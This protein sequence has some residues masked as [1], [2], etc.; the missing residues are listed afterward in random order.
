MP[1]GVRGCR[2]GI[3]D[4]RPVRFRWRAAPPAMRREQWIPCSIS[5]SAARPPEPKRALT[6]R[7]DQMSDSSAQAND[8][9]LLRV[10]GL[11]PLVVLPAGPAMPMLAQNGTGSGSENSQDRRHGSGSDCGPGYLLAD[12]DCCAQ[13]RSTVGPGIRGPGIRGAGIRGAG[14]C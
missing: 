5:A 13:D 14:P 8:R 3:A 1:P 12:E 11:W 10:A 7:N 4:V 9:G 6:G 2:H